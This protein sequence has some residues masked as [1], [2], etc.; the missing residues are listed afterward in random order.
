MSKRWTVHLRS[1]PKDRSALRKK[2]PDR[3]PGVNTG[4]GGSA[5]TRTS[6]VDMLQRNLIN[7]LNC[8]ILPSAEDVLTQGSIAHSI[9]QRALTN[10]DAAATTCLPESWVRASLLVR[11]N[12]LASGN[13]GVRTELTNSLLE[14]LQSN[15]TPVIPLRGSISA[16]GDLIPLSYIAAA[17]QGSPTVNV[18][19]SGNDPNPSSRTQMSAEAALA[20]SSLAPIRL[21]P[22][23]G[24]AIVNGTSVSTGVAALA[25]HDANCL[26]VLSQVLTAMTV[27]ALS[28]SI[29]NFDPFLAQ[30]RPHI[31]Q[32]DVSSN[33]HG[34]LAGSRLVSQEHN[35]YLN[36]GSLRQ[37]RYATR[38]APQW[39]GPQL[40]D[41]MLA[42]SQ[43]TIECNSTTD[44]PV[45]SIANQRI[46]HGGNFQA[47]TVSSAMEKTRSSAQIIGK[48]L[49]AQCTELINPAL[50][51]GLPPNL[52][53]DEPS[54]SFLM[55]GVDISIA[56]LQAELGFLASPMPCHAQTAEMGNQSLNSLALLSA[57]YTHIALDILSQLSAAHLFTLCQALDLRVLQTKFLENL[58]PLF[59]SKTGTLLS[60]VVNDSEML[61]R[62]L[63]LHF[64]REL[65]RTTS[66]DSAERFPH[67]VRSL[68]PTVLA[69]QA[70]P[71]VACTELIPALLQWTNNCADLSS[72]VYRQTCDAYLRHP[73][74]S[75]FLG[76]ASE[77]IYWFV[78]KELKVP[79]QNLEGPKVE[80]LEFDALHAR[81]TMHS[82]GSRISTIYT[83]VRNGELFVP[84]ME[85]L[86]EARD[87]DTAQSAKEKA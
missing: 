80:T 77:R 62:E 29:E 50:N 68:Q 67:I 44:N 14:M 81:S 85:C 7:F 20:K 42:Q 5:N 38:T 8:G 56:A 59:A 40:E 27:E 61:Q 13:S 33:I 49:F 69:F 36:D 75:G 86:R 63:W 32:V 35:I 17:I 9:F 66:M 24:L 71:D 82:T 54:Q 76:P 87:R 34:F 72:Q 43:I 39:I 55:K 48:M 83:A 16:S 18:W 60:Q 65:N 10:E 70:S 57:R 22:K 25:L 53:M 19:V 79:F 26:A 41:L 73:D 6:E 11:T 84:V 74:P 46:V 3:R 4:F 52:D 51:N 47:M 78:R 64:Q 12:S 1:V 23:E 58:K 37:D 30:I 28:G 15:V 2:K 45:I 31:G 21:G